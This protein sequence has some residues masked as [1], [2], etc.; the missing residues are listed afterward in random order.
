MIS[1]CNSAFPEEISIL[2]DYGACEVG[3]KGRIAQSS[4]KK[5]NVVHEIGEI[6]IVLK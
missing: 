6:V 5:G 1:L 2:N 4:I 3:K